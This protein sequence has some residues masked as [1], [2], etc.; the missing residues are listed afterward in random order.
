MID[1]NKFK[2]L[3]CH[4]CK[5]K[6]IEYYSGFIKCYTGC[7]FISNNR[8]VLVNISKDKSEKREIIY[9]F[10][11]TL[12]RH[13]KFSYNEN[14]DEYMY[15]KIYDLTVPVYID[16]TIMFNSIDFDSLFDKI[17]KLGAFK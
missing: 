2:S 16:P 12:I 8:F 17:K 9:D 15:K 4:D 6:I 11:N 7:T 10:G 3:M 5:T 13:Y 14:F 1:L